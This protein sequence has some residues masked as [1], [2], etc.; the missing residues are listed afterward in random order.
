[1][2]KQFESHDTSHASTKLVAKNEGDGDASRR[3]PNPAEANTS[4]ENNKVTPSKLDFSPPQTSVTRTEWKQPERQVRHQ[5]HAASSTVDG[6][7]DV[8]NKNALN[9]NISRG[10]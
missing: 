1:M 8:A 9:L 4:A 2:C 6:W 7:M 5:E 3:S 10:H